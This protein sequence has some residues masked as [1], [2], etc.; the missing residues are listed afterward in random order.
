M[1]PLSPSGSLL[2]GTANP[3]LQAH[4][5]AGVNLHNQM[6]YKGENKTININT[7]INNSSSASASI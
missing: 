2:N 6:S 4:W 7:N 3:S 1:Y 5:N